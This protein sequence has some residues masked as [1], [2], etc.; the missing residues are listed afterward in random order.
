[1][2]SS[3]AFEHVPDVETIVCRLNKLSNFC[4][5]LFLAGLLSQN[6]VKFVSAAASGRLPSDT[7][8]RALQL[9]EQR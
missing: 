2:A 7:P 4:I 8:A 1:M 3:K 6:T 9:W 5:N